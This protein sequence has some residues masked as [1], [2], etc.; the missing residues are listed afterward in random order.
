M[1]KN[2]TPPADTSGEMRRAM[3]ALDRCRRE[4]IEKANLSP[5]WQAWVIDSLAESRPITDA[6]AGA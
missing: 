2:K 3:L 1:S 4:I 6:E 5:E